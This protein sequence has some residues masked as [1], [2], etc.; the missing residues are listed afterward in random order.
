MKRMLLVLGLAGLLS[1]PSV[2]FGEATWYGSF[3]GGLES[4]GDSTHMFSNGSRWGVKGSNE[5]SE[6]L[7]ANYRYEEALDLATASL[8]T[9]NRLSYVGLSGGFG[10]ISIGRIW[11]ASWNSVG[12]ILDN[13]Y[14][15]GTSKTSYRV[16]P[17]VSYSNSVGAASVQLDLVM[18]KANSEKSGV[19]QYEFGLSMDLGAATLAFA[20]RKKHV[21]AVSEKNFVVGTPSTPTTVVVTEG[22]AGTPTRVS[23]TPGVLGTP[24]D[25]DVTP[26][27]A[28]TPTMVSVTTAGEAGTPTVVTVMQPEDG[29]DAVPP[30]Q[31][32]NLAWRVMN[33]NKAVPLL[34]EGATTAIAAA[35]DCTG[36]NQIWISAAEADQNYDV[37]GGAPV[38]AADGSAEGVMKE[39]CYSTAHGVTRTRSPVKSVKT[40][41]GDEG[42]NVPP[43]D[44]TQT[45]K[46]NVHRSR[47]DC[48]ADAAS[49]VWEPSG[50]MCYPNNADDPTADP[51]VI[52][53]LAQAETEGTPA[54]DPKPIMVDVE[55]GEAGTPTVV[56]VDNG[57]AGEPTEVTVVDG[58]ATT[59]TIVTVD[60]GTGGTPTTVEVTPGTAGTPSMYVTTEKSPAYNETLNAVAVKIAAGSHSAAVGLVKTS[61][62][63]NRE[64]STTIANAGGPLSDGLSYHFQIRDEEGSDN[65]WLIGLAKSLGG[66]SSLI[67]E[68]AK[69]NDENSTALYLQ[70]DF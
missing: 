61:D 38:Q 70:V 46:E 64:A 62:S 25:V 4:S 50:M 30:R 39:G 12:A 48:L 55:E 44:H 24:T 22:T 19:D 34:A 47:S 65:P 56:D 11:S 45:G 1:M 9:G 20:H 17:A 32:S 42:V 52:T 60:D 54:V 43:I 26:G 18:D 57:M 58:T 53:Y 14:V 3:R 28:N 59:P 63:L 35:T 49:N 33:P 36:T 7:S 31:E 6:G 15:Y 8:S 67:F 29:V 40:A 10:T 66:G 16:G 41:A 23:V 27:T 13:S 2:V 21:A 69:A 37:A 68:H 5:V 51:L